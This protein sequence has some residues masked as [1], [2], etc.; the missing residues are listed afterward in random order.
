MT[1]TKVCLLLFT[2][3]LFHHQK[4]KVQAINKRENHTALETRVSPQSTPREDWL[5]NSKPYKAKVYKGDGS[6]E[7]ILSS[8]LIRRIFLVSN[9]VTLRSDNLITGESQGEEKGMLVTYNPTG[10]EVKK[11]INVPLYYTGLTDKADISIA[12]GTSKEYTLNREYAV[13]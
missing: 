7:I 5:L 12:G 8:G 2:L 6:D 9:A 11:T 10:K 13:K 3:G 1:V 4:L